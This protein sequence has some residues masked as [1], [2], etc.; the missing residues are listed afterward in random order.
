MVNYYIIKFITF[1]CDG[2]EQPP[3]E[4]NKM[5][6]GP[7]AGSSVLHYCVSAAAVRW[8][9]PNAR[10]PPRTRDVWSTTMARP[11]NDA[12][13]NERYVMTS[14]ATWAGARALAYVCDTSSYRCAGV[15]MRNTNA[16][17]LPPPSNPHPSLSPKKCK[18]NRVWCDWLRDG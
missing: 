9:I 10:A 4:P 17:N 8:L 3:D 15:C 13:N 14:H 11:P 7:N 5:H 12:I 6:A 2:G 1:I 18:Q 16:P